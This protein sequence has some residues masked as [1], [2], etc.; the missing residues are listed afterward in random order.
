MNRHSATALAPARIGNV[1]VGFDVLGLSSLTIG[2][3]VRAKRTRDPYVTISSI[4]GVTV[5]LPIAPDK[6]TAGKAV[7]GLLQTMQPVRRAS[8]GQYELQWCLP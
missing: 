4:S 7:L 2:Y 3:R 1:A 8:R 5:D 6:N